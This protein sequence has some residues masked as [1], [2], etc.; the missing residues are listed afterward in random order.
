[1]DELRPPSGAGESNDDGGRGDLRFARVLGAMG[2]VILLLAALLLSL[3]S[4]LQGGASLYLI[5]YGIA[6]L[7]GPVGFWLLGEAWRIRN[8]VVHGTVLP[9]AHRRNLRIL[10][11]LLLGAGAFVAFSG[12]GAAGTIST[13]L[14]LVGG[15]TLADRA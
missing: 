9:P 6:A 15:L 2:T 5:A 4:F 3:P 1:M 13:V 7:F 8:R 11:V 10:G 14:N 12:I